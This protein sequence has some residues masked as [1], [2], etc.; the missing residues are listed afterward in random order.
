MLNHL[1]KVFV[2]AAV[3]VLLSSSS[4]RYPE[5]RS[6]MTRKFLLLTWKRL[7]ATWRIGAPAALEGLQLV[8]G[9]L[10]W[11]GLSFAHVVHLSQNCLMSVHIVGQ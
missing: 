7:V 1:A 3:F 4:H 2:T 6:T 5:W 11:L 8:M 9:A 10:V